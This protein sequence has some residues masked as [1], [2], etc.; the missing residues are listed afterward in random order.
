MESSL[1]R[2]FD[3]GNGEVPRNAGSTADLSF[4]LTLASP[5]PSGSHRFPRRVLVVH[6][7]GRWRPAPGAPGTVR[8]GPARAE[9]RVGWLPGHE[10]PEDVR[11]PGPVPGVRKAPS[12]GPVRAPPEVPGTGRGD[13]DRAV[14]SAGAHGVLSQRS[15]QVPACL[16]RK[17][18]GR[19]HN[20][21]QTRGAQSESVG[22]VRVFAAYELHDGADAGGGEGWRNRGRGAEI[23]DNG[24]KEEDVCGN[25]KK[26]KKQFITSFCL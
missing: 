23:E 16:A 5:P 22:V 7:G 21:V 20:G 3:S 6:N 18:R 9:R 4:L 12:K 8:P 13:R 11:R 14:L 15:D 19:A 26:K 10:A 17:Q 1:G 25:Y 24:E 2:W